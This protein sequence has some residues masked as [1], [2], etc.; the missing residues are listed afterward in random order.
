M[1]EREREREMYTHNL[2]S[3]TPRSSPVSGIHS[4]GGLISF[5][6][7]ANT[8]YFGSPPEEEEE[9]RGSVGTQLDFIVYVL[10]KAHETPSTSRSMIRPEP[11]PDRSQTMSN[12]P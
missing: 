1:C 6:V 8:V 11:V 12:V 5:A 4:P 2:T 7:G 9:R 3:H 10:Y